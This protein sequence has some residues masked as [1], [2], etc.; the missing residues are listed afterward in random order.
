M[1]ISGNIAD[2]MLSLKPE[3]NLSF[4]WI[5]FASSSLKRHQ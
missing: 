1:K 4:D 5:F 2:G 3:N